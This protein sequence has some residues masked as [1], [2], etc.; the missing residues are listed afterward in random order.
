MAKRIVLSIKDL[1]RSDIVS[2]VAEAQEVILAMGG[3]DRVTLDFSGVT[4]VDK[5]FARELFSSWRK[6]NPHVV[7]NIVGASSSVAYEIENAFKTK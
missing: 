5:D 1:F 7:L 4:S 6:R 3:Y 2:S